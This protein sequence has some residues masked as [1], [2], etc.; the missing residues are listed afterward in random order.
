MI[1]NKLRPSLFLKSV[2]TSVHCQNFKCFIS[3][4]KRGL[5]S[6]KVS[7]IIFDGDPGVTLSKP[8][9]EMVYAGHM[10]TA[11]RLMLHDVIAQRINDGG[12]GGFALREIVRNLYVDMRQ[13]KLITSSPAFEW[14]IWDELSNEEV[15][16]IIESKFIS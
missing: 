16:K 13:R 5:F 8:V 14:E 6:K 1:V 10:E 7:T 12:E 2:G 11:T 3:T 4:A 9:V 15:A